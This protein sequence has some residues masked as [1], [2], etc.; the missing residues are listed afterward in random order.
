M[1][2]HIKDEAFFGYTFTYF[3]ENCIRIVVYQI[4]KYSNLLFIIKT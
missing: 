2:I 4:I 1:I 3:Y